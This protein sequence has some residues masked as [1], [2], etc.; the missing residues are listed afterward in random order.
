MISNY[1]VCASIRGTHPIAGSM[2]LFQIYH[3]KWHM[4]YI[5]IVFKEIIY[6]IYCTEIYELKCSFYQCTQ[7]KKKHECRNGFH[8]TSLYNM[9]YKTYDMATEGEATVSDPST[10]LIGLNASI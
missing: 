6:M 10:L 5:K 4:L 1:W 7:Y 3:F 2:I 9:E 8:I